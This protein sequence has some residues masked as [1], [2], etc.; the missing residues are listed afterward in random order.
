MVGAHWDLG[1][2]TIISLPHR[3]LDPLEE[4]VSGEVGRQHPRTFHR[5]LRR[6]LMQVQASLNQQQHPSTVKGGDEP[7][8]DKTVIMEL[9]LGIQEGLQLRLMLLQS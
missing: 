2:G 3:A 5:N 9:P 8:C 4:V 1:K 6:H 7:D